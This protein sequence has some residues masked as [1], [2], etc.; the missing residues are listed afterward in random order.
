MPFNVKKLLIKFLF[1]FRSRKNGTYTTGDKSLTQIFE[2][3]PKQL[4]YVLTILTKHSF[5]EK[6]A[7]SSQKQRSIVYLKRFEQ[8]NETNLEKIV[9]Y[10]TK[11]PDKQEYTCTL[12]EKFNLGTK[13]FKNLAA[14]G[15]KQ[16]LFR[17][18]AMRVDVN[19]SIIV[20]EDDDGDEEDDEF[21]EADDTT[22]KKKSK[23]KTKCVR[24]LKLVNANTSLSATVNEED[25]D[26]DDNETNLIDLTTLCSE[27][28]IDLPLYTQIFNYIESCGQSGVSLK[29]LGNLFGFDFY[30]SRRIGAHLQ[31]HPDIV[32]L[33]KETDRGKAKYQ[34]IVMRKFLDNLKNKNLASSVAIN[35]SSELNVKNMECKPIQALASERSIK[36]REI[37]LNYLEQ[38]KICS[39]FEIDKEIRRIEELEKQKGQIDAKTTKR[40]LVQLQSEFKLRVFEFKVKNKTQTGVCLASITE[41]DD[42]YINYLNT[43]SRSFDFCINNRTTTSSSTVPNQDPD[44]TVT[45]EQSIDGEFQLTRTYVQSV[46]GKLEFSFT[47]A[48]HYGIV[49]KIQKAIILH[50]FLHYILYFNNES[51]KEIKATNYDFL[52]QNNQSM[53]HENKFNFKSKITPAANISYS[54][55]QP[56]SSKSLVGQNKKVDAELYK[57]YEIVNSCIPNACYSKDT[58][59]WKT[60]I[61]P[62]KMN[63]SIPKN[64]LFISD[65]LSCMPLS[66]FTS[67]IAI[68]YRIPGLLSLLKHPYKRHM[69]IKDLPSEILAAFIHDR[70]YLQRVL[71]VLQ[72]LSCL[73]LINFVE[74]PKI[75]NQSSNRSVESQ[76]VYISRQTYM[77]DTTVNTFCKWSD[78]ENFDSD[79]FKKLIFKF[80]NDENILLFWK[81]LL[82]ISLNTY[83]FNVTANLKESKKLRAILH[84]NAC[85]QLRIK[86]IGDL[87]PIVGDHLGPGGYDS[88]LFLNSYANWTLPSSTS[89]KS[90]SKEASSII[91]IEYDDKID[92]IYSELVMQLPFG[93]L[94][95]VNSSPLTPAKKKT[96]AK[97]RSSA[98]AKTEDEKSFDTENESSPKKRKILP[99]LSSPIKKSTI[100][101]IHKMSSSSQDTMQSRKRVLTNRTKN[102]ALSSKKSKMYEFKLNLTKNLVKKAKHFKLKKAKEQ[103]GQEKAA[104]TMN[105]IKSAAIFKRNSEQKRAVWNKEEDDLILL[106]KI[107][108]LYFLPNEKT[109]QFKIIHDIMNDLMPSTYGKKIKSF[110]RRMKVLLKSKLNRL[111]ISNKLELCRQNDELTKLY[112]NVKLKRNSIANQNEQINIYKG[113]ILDVKS[114]LNKNLDDLT[115][116]FK[117]PDSIEELH[118]KYTIKSQ[119]DIFK[120]ESYFKQPVN[121]NEIL[122]STLHS[123]IHVSFIT[124]YT[125]S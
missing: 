118:K 68:N 8:K 125:F 28:K 78:I 123:A 26:F 33:V 93:I 84:K 71:S 102:I 110:G 55:L 113:F 76:M 119:N 86:D 30:K 96:P 80:D 43:F 15:E 51:N 23:N 106:I 120:Q 115:S 48:K 7:I 17:R 19:S 9:N 112:S 122:Q 67:I 39:K 89:S 116:D 82:N 50:R 100:Q 77:R 124:Q 36:R 56:P 101:R 10:L 52:I 42:V 24:I 29:Q 45:K 64:C 79:E 27:Q 49:S 25:D 99:Y 69:L 109:I 11:K 117:L 13:Q 32:T 81:S 40:M 58:L 20:N 90:S 61:P 57:E 65:I 21:E 103:K 5:I 44:D 63:E 38:H 72:F 73:N 66:V 37:V 22:E 83:K 104:E 53:F 16:N 91:S 121:N 70:R 88:Q 105:K 108:S 18:V 14:L 34:T 54:N 41:E 60:F 62:L 3:A 1:E 95:G 94:R 4:H 6:K 47:F 59:S 75:I 97:R 107:A 111:Y 85:C 92:N 35:K 31:T 87:K 114:K 98:K 12:R 2:I 46:V 74:H